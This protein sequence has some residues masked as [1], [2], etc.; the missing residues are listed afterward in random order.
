MRYGTDT[1]NTTGNNRQ[2]RLVIASRSRGRLNTVT[3]AVDKESFSEKGAP[4]FSLTVII[5]VAR[6][7]TLLRL[8]RITCRSLSGQPNRFINR[9]GT[10]CVYPGLYYPQYR[11]L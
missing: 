2:G 7:A 9:Q 1:D 6:L 3:P 4:S 10:Y 8:Y 5:E 11:G